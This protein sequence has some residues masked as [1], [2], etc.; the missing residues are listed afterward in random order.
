MHD[1]RKYEFTG[2]ERKTVTLEGSTVNVYR[3]R[4]TESFG[5]V[6]A[7]ETGGWIEGRGNLSDSGNAW[8]Y[9][10]AVVCGNSRVKG[11]AEVSGKAAV[12]GDA[13][14]QG[15][16]VV[17]GKAKISGSVVVRDSAK[18]SGNVTAYEDAVIEENA[19]V[20]GNAVVRGKAIVGGNSEVWH[21]ADVLSANHILQIGAI[22]R[23]KE[24]M[25]FY[26]DKDGEVTVQFGG[27]CGKTWEL[28]KS[29]S[30]MHGD[31]GISRVYSM[32]VELA[33]TQIGLT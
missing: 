4:A 5:I 9:D 8:V 10:D 25:T 31:K 2:E 14:I 20:Y 27:F 23:G 30:D 15:S 3:I 33:E 1:L 21:N 11:D 12:S 19:E 6:K 32:A 16:A 17:R 7:G 26:R 29:I 18:M 28:L 13:V 24:P 22:E